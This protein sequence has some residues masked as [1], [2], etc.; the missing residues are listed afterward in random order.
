MIWRLA[1]RSVKV[2]Q[3]RWQPA[4]QAELKPNG[5]YSVMLKLFKVCVFNN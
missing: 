2:T 3:E 1:S 4:L 5:S